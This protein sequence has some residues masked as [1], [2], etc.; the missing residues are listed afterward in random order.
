MAPDNSGHWVSQD[1]KVWHLMDE[2]L[3]HTL[4][5][6]QGALLAQK[7]NGWVGMGLQTWAL[8]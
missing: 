7:W 5:G 4:V 8:D 3:C 2:S 1:L 6:G